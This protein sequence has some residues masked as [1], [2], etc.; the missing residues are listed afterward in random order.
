MSKE[1]NCRS[2]LFGICKDSI[3][4]VISTNEKLTVSG[5]KGNRSPLGTGTT[6]STNT[7][8]IVLRVVRIIVIQN[9]CNVSDIFSWN[10]VS[11]SGTRWQGKTR[12]HLA[13]V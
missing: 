8:N 1:Q 11:K 6:S 2:N 4:R 12:R 3:S 5:E 7:M 10:G 13:V 9:M